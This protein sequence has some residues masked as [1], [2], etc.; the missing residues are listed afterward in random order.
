MSGRSTG[1]DAEGERVLDTLG[2]ANGRPI[3][4]CTALRRKVGSNP[5]DARVASA[6]ANDEL[7]AGEDS[8]APVGDRRQASVGPNLPCPQ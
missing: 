6:L 2:G 3:N 1:T 7:Y 5:L 4:Q 8:A